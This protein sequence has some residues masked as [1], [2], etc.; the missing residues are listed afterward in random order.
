MNE[1]EE[2]DEDEIMI[3]RIGF[4][5]EFDLDQIKLKKELD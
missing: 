3:E 1:V 5:H 2:I 4:D